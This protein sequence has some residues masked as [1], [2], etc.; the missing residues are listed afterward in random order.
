M[1][2]AGLLALAVLTAASTLRSDLDFYRRS[3]LVEHHAR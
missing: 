3:V 2:I 1:I